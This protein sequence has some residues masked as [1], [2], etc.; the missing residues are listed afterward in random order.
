MKKPMLTLP[1]ALLALGLAFVNTPTRADWFAN[2]PTP[3]PGAAYEDKVNAD[4]STSQFHAEGN[5]DVTA[6]GSYGYGY[7]GGYPGGSQQESQVSESNQWKQTYKWQGEASET[8]YTFDVT[9][10]GSASGSCSVSETGFN[11]QSQV[12]SHVYCRL[13]GNDAAIPLGG[14]GFAQASGYGGSSRT[15]SYN[16]PSSGTKFVLPA[17]VDGNGNSTSFLTLSVDVYG[18]GS[19]YFGGY[20]GHCTASGQF[21]GPIP[22]G[23]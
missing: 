13:N 18:S 8:P 14:Y 20:S 7:P 2:V 5:F 4:G 22:H 17:G 6:P 15:G 12:G 11:N 21:S 23:L 9:A 19:T 16:S 10:S 1:V 3:V